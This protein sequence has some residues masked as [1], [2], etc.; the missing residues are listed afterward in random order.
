MNVINFRTVFK[1]ALIRTSVAAVYSDH[2]EKMDLEYKIPILLK[3]KMIIV[4]LQLS[5]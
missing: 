1:K 2:C 3:Y 4:L 5:R